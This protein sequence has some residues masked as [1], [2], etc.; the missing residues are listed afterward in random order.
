V[1]RAASSARVPVIPVGGGSGIVGG[2][3]AEAGQVIVDTRRMTSFSLEPENCTVTAGCGLTCAELEE[4]LGRRGFTSGHFPQSGHS[5]TLGGMAATRAVGTFS[6]RYG[7]M[8]DMVSGL[9]VALADGR[10]LRTHPAPRRSSGPELLQLFLGSEGTLGVITEVSMKVYR[11]PESRLFRT[12]VFPDTPAGLRAARQFVQAGARP[13]VVRLY[14]EAESAGWLTRLGLPPGGSFLV[15]VFEG[16]AGLVRAEE[17][18][19]MAAC[20][21]AG[22]RDHGPEGAELWFEGRYATRKMLEYHR[23]RGKTADA[24]EVA[25]P[26]NRI[27]A[28]WREMRR[29]LQPACVEIDCHFSHFYHTGASVYV[30]FYADTGSDDVAAERRY[31]E[32]LGLAVEASLANGGNVSHHHGIGRSRAEWM[33]REHGPEGVEVL[34]G[35][36]RALDPLGIMNPGVLGL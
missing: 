25:A 5:A 30:I 31:R 16:P 19:T 1:L 33:A 8:D 26:W 13:A 7:K 2:T 18:L 32:C 11:A 14:D 12:C 10:I 35:I 3:M 21:E 6:T 34:R 17:K 22:G 23:G 28:V 24:V 4:A 27:E 20:R 29:A 9:E 15:L 36:K